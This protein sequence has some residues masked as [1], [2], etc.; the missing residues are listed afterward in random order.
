MTDIAWDI[1]YTPEPEKT[2]HDMR[3]MLGLKTADEE[4]C[5][6][7][8]ELT[9]ED[10]GNKVLER[11]TA[12]DKDV[13]KKADELLTSIN[14]NI[15]EAADNKRSKIEPQEC[16]YYDWNKVQDAKLVY[17]QVARTLRS[18]GFTVSVKLVKPAFWNSGLYYAFIMNVSWNKCWCTAKLSE[19]R[20]RYC[21]STQ[22][23]VVLN[24]S[25]KAE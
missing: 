19:W 9:A 20:K 10:A 2:Y 8:M 23:Q 14:G 18:R 3:A 6:L 5:N 15:S 16:H 7:H 24:Q 21:I 1:Y 11:D 22:Y 4:A 13:Q 12:Y 17:R 25:E